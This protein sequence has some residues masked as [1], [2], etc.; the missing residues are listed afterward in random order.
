MIAA[1]LGS[2]FQ[3]FGLVG[4]RPPRALPWAGVGRPVG[5]EMGRPPRALPWAGVGRPVG[6]PEGQRPG[7]KA[8]QGNAL[9]LGLE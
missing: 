3:G 8:A 6:A 2:P 1:W 9:G 7:F 5:A 4:G